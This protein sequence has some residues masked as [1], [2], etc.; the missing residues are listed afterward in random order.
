MT[1]NIFDLPPVVKLE[2]NPLLKIQTHSSPVDEHV[3]YSKTLL[4]KAGPGTKHRR[5][6][7][8]ACSPSFP[9]K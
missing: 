6:I 1:Q 2:M 7:G 4:R 8:T 5:S 3:Q 9:R